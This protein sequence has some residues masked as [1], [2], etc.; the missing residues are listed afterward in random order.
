MKINKIVNLFLVACLGIFTTAAQVKETPDFSY[1]NMGSIK[2]SKLTDAGT[3][4]ISTSNGIYGVQPKEKEAKVLFNQRKNIKEENFTLIPNSP[5][6]MFVANG[7]NGV[8]FVIDIISGKTLVDSKAL[9]FN[10][11]S[12]RNIV[13]PENKF[14]ISGL[15][16]QE[17]KIGVAHS[18]SVIDLGTGKEEHSVIDNGKNPV[19]GVPDMVNGKLIIPRKKG[20]DGIDLN[21]SK[22][23]WS[24]EVKN[25]NWVQATGKS[26]YA[27]SNVGNGKKTKMYKINENGKFAWEDGYTV[28]GKVRTVSDLEKGVAVLSDVDNSNKGGGMLMKMAMGKSESKIYFLDAKTGK[29]LWEKAPKTKGF[30]SH[31]YTEDDAIIFGVGSGGINKVSYD[32]VPLWKKP[33]KT[34]P[35]ISTLARTPKGILYITSTDT[36]IVDET[37]G[38]SVLKSKLKY[39]GKKSV[40][41]GY[42]KSKDRYL[43]SCSDGLFS[44]DANQGTFDKIASPKFGEKEMPTSIEI[45]NGNILLSSSQNMMLLDNKGSNIYHEHYKSPTN[46]G[47]FKAVM[48][49]VGTASAVVMASS[50]WT[51]GANRM[52]GG[53]YTSFGNQNKIRADGFANIASAS[54]KAM[55]QRFKASAKLDQSQFMLTKFDSG[56]GLVNI[57]KDSGKVI[58]KIL[59]KDK[60]PDYKIDEVSRILYYTPNKN[61][62]KAYLF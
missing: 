41:S 17:G 55:S 2:W 57:D 32:G 53:Y 60:K 59:L 56:V 36:D 47:I 54:F 21:T 61:T 8:T 7:I 37:T 62:I 4:V 45:R 44:I 1:Q 38:K 48:A 51:A 10:Q 19:T 15:R 42:D 35:E 5:Y 24:T 23:V 26:I 34:G 6:A 11:V 25:I 49:V 39:K 22:V 3:L 40:A 27:F 16:K 18:I 9:K 28:R 43:V 50:A 31:F 29:D 20:I 14:V 30:I 33:L 12:S 52:P 13:M 58:N 46:S